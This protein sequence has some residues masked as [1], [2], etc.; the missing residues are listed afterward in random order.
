VAENAGGCAAENKLAHSRMAVFP[1][2]AGSNVLRVSLEHLGDGT[3][4]ASHGRAAGE[5]VLL[6][7]VSCNDCEH[8]GKRRVHAEAR[9]LTRAA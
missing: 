2:E 7:H 9:D 1:Y 3:S 5:L 4:R 6:G 8:R